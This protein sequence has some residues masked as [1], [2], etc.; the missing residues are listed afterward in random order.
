[1]L[2]RLRIGLIDRYVFKMAAVATVVLLFGLTAVLWITQAL[3]EV[4]LITGKGQTIIIFLTI[5]VLAIPT[6]L[7]GIAPV[8]LFAGTLYTLNKLNGD[9]ELIVMTAGGLRPAQLLKPFIALTALVC[10]FVAWMTMIIIP[11][12]YRLVRDLVT[13]IRADFVSNIAKEGQFITLDQGITFHYREKQGDVLL[14]IFFQDGR[15]Q[16]KTSVYIAERGRTVE[17]EGNSFMMLD[18]GSIQRTTQGRT[19]ASIITFDSYALNLS[20]LGGDGGDGSGD[21][22]IYKPR[23]RPTGELIFPDTS[24]AYYKIQQGRFRAELHNRL[25]APLYPIAFMLIAFAALGEART[26]RQGRGA[27]IQAAIL[28]VSATR[29]GGY[30]AWSASV[31][32]PKAVLVM[33]GLPIFAI[34]CAGV[35]IT[36]G[37]RVLDPI[38]SRVMGIID[39]VI[40]RLAQ[41]RQAVS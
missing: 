20:S 7:A 34:L 24:D 40:E 35:V 23:E 5:T 1:M 16:G 32:S 29:I 10:A 31:S 21:K 13:K 8:A 12:D 22:V 39:A 27:A 26:T 33:Y 17:V 38:T 25:S 11:Q 37:S 3:R 14:G 6:L 2:P 19:D 28:I 15:D 30:M 41:R 4:D 36:R 18:K 9:S